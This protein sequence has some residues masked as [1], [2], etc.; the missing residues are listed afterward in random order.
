MTDSREIPE[1]DGKV[2]D[3]VV[4]TKKKQATNAVQII[5]EIVKG[6]SKLIGEGGTGQHSQA[7]RSVLQRRKK[8]TTWFDEL[9]HDEDW[10]ELAA[11]PPPADNIS[12]LERAVELSELYPKQKLQQWLDR[13]HKL[14][15]LALHAGSTACLI[16]LAGIRNTL[17]RFIVPDG[18]LRDALTVFPAIYETEPNEDS[19]A[20][21]DYTIVLW[22]NKDSEQLAA[23][24]VALVVTATAL[25]QRDDLDLIDVAI[26]GKLKATENLWLRLLN[27]EPGKAIREFLL[28]DLNRDVANVQTVAN[29]ELV[30]N[31]IGKGMWDEFTEKVQLVIIQFD[32]DV[33]ISNWDH[34]GIA[35][36]LDILTYT[37]ENI[38]EWRAGRR[39]RYPSEQVPQVHCVPDDSI[40]PSLRSVPTNPNVWLVDTKQKRELRQA[41][42][43]EDSFHELFNELSWDATKKNASSVKKN[44]FLLLSMQASVPVGLTR[45]SIEATTLLNWLLSNSDN[46]LQQKDL[47]IL[48]AKEPDFT[49]FEKLKTFLSG[50]QPDD[51]DSE[52]LVVQSQSLVRTFWPPRKHTWRMQ[53]RSAVPSPLLPKHWAVWKQAM[54]FALQQEKRINMSTLKPKDAVWLR[55]QIE[56]FKETTGR[57]T[58][59]TKWKQWSDWKTPAKQFSD[60]LAKLLPWIGTAEL[61]QRTDWLITDGE[62]RK[63]RIGE[64]WMKQWVSDLY[65]IL[66][67][68]FHVQ[69][70]V[71]LIERSID[72]LQ[73]PN[74][75]AAEL[76][77]TMVTDGRSH[78][79][80]F[81]SYNDEVENFF[82]L[83]REA[84][85]WL[86]EVDKSKVN[87]ERAQETTLLVS[88]LLEMFKILYKQY[89]DAFDGFTQEIHDM[90]RDVGTDNAVAP[91][92]SLLQSARERLKVLRRSTVLPLLYNLHRLWEILRDT[93]T[94]DLR[95]P[96]KLPK[97]VV[98]VD[99]KEFINPVTVKK[100]LGNR[101]LAGNAEDTFN[102]LQQ[103]DRV[104]EN[105]I[106]V[107]TTQ[108]MLYDSQWQDLVK[109]IK[110]MLLP[111]DESWLRKVD[112]TAQGDLTVLAE[113]KGRLQKALAAD[114]HSR[115]KVVAKLH[116]FRQQEYAKLGPDHIVILA[117]QSLRTPTPTE[118]R[119]EISRLKK[120]LKIQLDSFL[121][122]KDS[123]PTLL[124]RV[125]P[126]LQDSYQNADSVTADLQKFSKLR[127]EL[128]DLIN[129]VKEMQS[130]VNEIQRKT[131]ED[132]SDS[133]A[134]AEESE[135]E[136]EPDYEPDSE[137]D[138]EDED[139]AGSE[140]DPEKMHSLL[141]RVLEKAKNELSPLKPV[142]AAS[143][144]FVKQEPSTDTV[145]ATDAADDAEP[146]A[147]YVEW[148]WNPQDGL[149]EPWP[150][151]YYLPTNEIE[152]D[153]E[154]RELIDAESSPVLP[155]LQLPR[156]TVKTED[157][158]KQASK[159]RRVEEDEAG[160]P[161]APPI[162]TG[163]LEDMDDEKQEAAE[164]SDNESD[165]E[166][167]DGDDPVH[168]AVWMTDLENPDRGDADFEDIQ[169]DS[170]K[171]LELDRRQL[172]DKPKPSVSRKRK[173][174]TGPKVDSSASEKD[175]DIETV[176]GI[177]QHSKRFSKLSE[178]EKLTK[179]KTEVLKFKTFANTIAAIVDL[180]QRIQAENNAQAT[181][182]SRMR[183]HRSR[184]GGPFTADE[185]KVADEWGQTIDKVAPE[186]LSYLYKKK[187]SEN[188]EKLIGMLKIAFDKTLP[189]PPSEQGKQPKTR[190][191][192]LLYKWGNVF[193]LQPKTSEEGRANDL[194][195][196]KRFLVHFLRLVDDPV[197][198]KEQEK[199]AKRE[200]LRVNKPMSKSKPKPKAAAADVLPYEETDNPS[201]RLLK[202]FDWKRARLIKT[203]DAQKREKTGTQIRKALEK[204][205]PTAEFLLEKGADFDKDEAREYELERDG[206]FRSIGMDKT[207]N[208]LWIGELGKLLQTIEDVTGTAPKYD[209]AIDQMLKTPLLTVAPENPEPE[210][211]I[212]LENYDLDQL[213]RDDEEE[214]ATGDVDSEYYS[215]IDSELY[216]S[217]DETVS[218]QG[219]FDDE[220]FEDL[221]GLSP[222]RESFNEPTRGSKRSA[223][224]SAVFEE[225]PKRL[226][227]KNGSVSKDVWRN[228]YR[229]LV[230]DSGGPADVFETTIEMVWHEINPG[231]I[232]HPEAQFVMRSINSADRMSEDAFV[233]EIIRVLT[234]SSPNT[235][236]IKFYGDQQFSSG[237]TLEQVQQQFQKLWTEVNGPK[238]VPKT[239]KFAVTK[240]HGGAL[241]EQQ[242]VQ[243]VNFFFLKTKRS[244]QIGSR[245]RSTGDDNDE[246]EHWQ[247]MLE[248]LSID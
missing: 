114:F 155:V 60:F 138:S 121:R 52:E 13:A 228:A 9:G 222:E 129:N 203:T 177:L 14:Y 7:V 17:Q 162:L 206:L 165:D 74:N 15:T 79:N 149:E 147:L 97:L 153:D 184:T 37:D 2:Q 188:T 4:S 142:S 69:I 100:E 226:K 192:V 179:V 31:G 200:R 53:L 220:K 174:P 193:R 156:I 126:N 130:L 191:T 187:P 143:D 47:M 172:S 108:G 61:N 167:E 128:V 3:E 180:G 106:N 36:Y 176:R 245:M 207:R 18:L 201:D 20:K 219:D 196:V 22:E 70:S 186:I 116:L 152:G 107:V 210:V 122:V 217:A 25:V 131:P 26:Q 124:D 202:T 49:D 55:D 212:N 89:D 136:A 103:Y 241:T 98:I 38:E 83:M 91:S 151:Q 56:E 216:S 111:E 71:T 246:D 146:I 82:V 59:G 86:D 178:S 227:N 213:E 145:D 67:N 157:Q 110:P 42:F 6:R 46:R 32:L 163:E 94:D 154:L 29:H 30:Q 34:I 135:P 148:V 73:N 164:Y 238:D 10:A 40:E 204:T 109:A 223:L 96:E 161:F 166:S 168:M 92:V 50:E 21:P 181:S 242:W 75:I 39:A 244:S 231:K 232:I 169:S 170:L 112:R 5:A 208:D 78:S 8:D 248:S 235:R 113:L 183:K 65:T 90:K 81:V 221:P 173:S 211:A 194:T 44:L 234:Q 104:I 77:D 160:F 80:L 243:L 45:V 88:E 237:A 72:R 198:R 35:S 185:Q 189:K 87:L 127:N 247:R 93:R 224:E 123:N 24:G 1:I 95:L 137:S 48:S 214:P 68:I 209:E 236:F 132:V 190:G 230:A 16:D 225:V 239:V 117:E 140:V 158:A 11:Y 133:E 229:D 120:A 84:R 118:N 85:L 105:S 33:Y 54:D 99:L 175:P 134:E 182:G 28:F 240:L 205:L 197:Y 144:T 139:E 199:H 62:R 141:T 19:K 63:L 233:E 41:R 27:G 119:R 51:S 57:K 66:K 23:V 102:R 115:L 159:R 101:I 125:E 215:D 150:K 64:D 76:A 58:T 218:E 195:E 43:E 12:R 171:T